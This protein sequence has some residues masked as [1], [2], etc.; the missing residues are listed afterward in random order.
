MNNDKSAIQVIAGAARCPE[1]LSL[2]HIFFNS[3]YTGIG[4]IYP[5]WDRRH[6]RQDPL[7]FAGDR[8][9]FDKHCFISV[10]YTHLDVYKRQPTPHPLPFQRESVRSSM[11]FYLHFNL[12][13]GRSPGFLAGSDTD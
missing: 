9:A 1:Y 6:L 7:F 2:I 10:S 11:E 4:F 8:K 5:D 12:D 3:R 13:M